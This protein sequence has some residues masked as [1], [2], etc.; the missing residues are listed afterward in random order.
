MDTHAKQIAG[1]NITYEDYEAG[2][3][4]ATGVARTSELQ[5]WVLGPARGDQRDLTQALKS[6]SQLQPDRRIREE[7][8]ARDTL[9]LIFTSGTTGMPKA[10]RITHVRGQLYMRGFAGS[11]DA[12]ETD[13]IFL[14]VEEAN[15]ARGLYRRAGFRDA[16]IYRYWT[17]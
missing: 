7:L 9:L 17:R 2:W 3:D 14:Q 13:R 4:S 11:T 12:R 15:P 16:W 1:L 6:C 8:K 10:A 5:L